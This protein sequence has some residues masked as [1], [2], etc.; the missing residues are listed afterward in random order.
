MVGEDLA[1]H[2]A[3]RPSSAADPPGHRLDVALDETTARAA[4]SELSRPI[5]SSPRSRRA[6]RPD[7][8]KSPRATRNPGRRCRGPAAAAGA[9]AGPPTGGRRRPG[10]RRT[11]GTGRRAGAACRAGG[12]RCRTARPSTRRGCRSWSRPPSRRAAPPSIVR[13]VSSSGGIRRS[14]TC[15]SSTPIAPSGNTVTSSSNVVPS[16]VDRDAVGGDEPRPRPSTTC[17]GARLA[18]WVPTSRSG[19]RT[20]RACW[21]TSRRTARRGACGDRRSA[22]SAR[23]LR[24]IA[25]RSAGEIC[26]GSRSWMTCS[27]RSRYFAQRDQSEPD[28]DERHGQPEAEHEVRVAPCRTRRRRR[29]RR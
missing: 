29:C 17:A 28:A 19:R 26:N 14:T 6:G 24:A 27:S 21:R 16:S 20:R 13:A 2:L 15:E 7:R 18:A 5:A 4:A 11:G 25:S 9:I 10:R 1:Q 22:S 3:D 12:C 23:S 8:S